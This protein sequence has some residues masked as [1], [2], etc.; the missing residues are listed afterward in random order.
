MLVIELLVLIL[1][2]IEV[3]WGVVE[4]L[5]ARRARKKYEREIREALTKLDPAHAQALKDLVLRRTQPSPG[6]G[7]LLQ[8]QMY[9]SLID[10]DFVGWKV[11]EEH[12]PFLEEWA[13]GTNGP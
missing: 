1:I 9:F 5:K 12:R 11:K 6:V 10:R 4:R 13:K 8:G 2:T 3:G 7:E